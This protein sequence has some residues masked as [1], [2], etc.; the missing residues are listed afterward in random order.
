VLTANPLPPFRS[1]PRVSNHGGGSSVPKTE[2]GMADVSTEDA[3][4]VLDKNDPNYD[5]GA[6]DA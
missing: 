5:D 3:V 4:T 2:M 6:D 1:G